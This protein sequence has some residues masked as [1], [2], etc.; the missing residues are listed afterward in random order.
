MTRTQQQRLRRQRH[1]RQSLFLTAWCSLVLGLVFLVFSLTSGRYPGE[2]GGG[3]TKV[4]TAGAAVEAPAVS[5]RE[6]ERFGGLSLSLG[7]GG[8][9]AFGTSHTAAFQAAGQGSPWEGIKTFLAEYDLTAVSLE[10]PLCRGGSPH[11]DQASVRLR[12][13]ISSAAP[14]AAAGID[15]LCLAND[16]VMDYG[17]RG[18]E[19]TM[20]LLR[21][22]K[23]AVCG[24]GSDRRAAAQPL[25]LKSPGGARVALLSYS[26]VEP[27]SYAAGE[28]TPGVNALPSLGEL[29]AAVSAAAGE[30]PYVVVMVHWGEAGGREIT[31]RQREIAYVC[32]R[33]GADL[34]VGCHP[35]FM[36]GVEMVEGTPV[37]YSL[38]D[39][40]YPQRDGFVGGLLAGCRFEDGYLARL[41]LFAVRCGANGASLL[42]G[43]EARKALEELAAVSPGVELRISAGGDSASL[44]L[45]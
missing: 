10:S 35:H 30:A 3:D 11:P 16:H 12:G 32:A 41:E 23:L 14:M 2:G 39:L 8:D 25:V 40:L 19:E 26:D 6:A 31:S 18:L 1:R 5:L 4:E 13:D 37:I 17:A 36:Q 33:A 20:N 9:V 38:G 7:L 45:R 29:S 22:E 34:V 15:A 28:G 43:E 21:G 27:R 44:E 42:Q 24:A